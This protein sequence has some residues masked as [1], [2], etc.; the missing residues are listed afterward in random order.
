[1][2]SSVSPSTVIDP[3]HRP[4]CAIRLESN[5]TRSCER[6]KC[7]GS[8]WGG[9]DRRPGE[10]ERQ[11]ELVRA[12][13]HTEPLQAFEYLHAERPDLRVHPSAPSSR[14]RRD[15]RYPH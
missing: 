9:I 7:C 3:V 8:T 14:G 12:E 1:V 11:P 10:I 6:M 15:T 2:T 13:D 5:T 4:V